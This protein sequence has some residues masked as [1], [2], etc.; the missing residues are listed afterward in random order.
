MALDAGSISVNSE[1]GAHSGSGAA[2]DML[3]AWW[4]AEGASRY[5]GAATSTIVAVMEE[6]PTTARPGEPLAKLVDRMQKRR[7]SSII[8]ST[9]DGVFAGVLRRE[10]GERRLAEE[11]TTGDSGEGS[12]ANS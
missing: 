1:T 2:Y 5:D 12:A 9:P 6:G 11:G 8:V 7:V 10:D 4:T 3:D